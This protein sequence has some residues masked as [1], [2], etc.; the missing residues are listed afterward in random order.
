MKI[1]SV[2]GQ[3]FMCTLSGGHTNWIRAACYSPDA[4]TI[5]SG[6]DD[7]TVRLWDARGP[8]RKPIHTFYE[9]TGAVRPCPLLPPSL[10]WPHCAQCV[11]TVVL[12]RAPKELFG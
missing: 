11:L 12:T 7:K 1:W 8:Q 2:P 4:R 6:G 10:L 3:R 5:V 9:H